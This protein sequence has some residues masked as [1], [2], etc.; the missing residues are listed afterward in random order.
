MPFVE[1]L[2]AHVRDR[3]AASATASGMRCVQVQDPVRHLDKHRIRP[4]SG[5]VLVETGFVGDA[6]AGI[7]LDGVNGVATDHQHVARAEL[8]HLADVVQRGVQRIR[9]CPPRWRAPCG[10]IRDPGALIL[11][12]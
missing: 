7:A 3:F 2:R 12:G 1:D 10:T 11:P 8:D 4:P 5:E 6:E 9:I